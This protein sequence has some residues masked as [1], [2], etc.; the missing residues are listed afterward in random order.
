MTKKTLEET[1]PHLKYLWHPTLNTNPKYQFNTLTFGSEVKVHWQCPD[2]PHHW[3]AAVRNVVSLGTRCN[4]CANQVVFP[5][6]NDFETHNPDKAKYWDYE[7]NDKLPSEVPKSSAKKFWFICENGHSFDIKTNA[8]NSGNWCRYCVNR[9]V[10]PGENDVLTLHPSLREIWS[11]KNTIDPTTIP[12]GSGRKVVWECIRGHEWTRAVNEATSSPSCPQCSGR[13]AT[14]ERNVAVLYPELI[15]LY[16]EKNTT[17]LSSITP[18]SEIKRE[19]VCSE[20]HEWEATPSSLVRGT[21]C[22]YCSNRRISDTNSLSVTHPDISAEWHPTLNE[23]TPRDVTS[24]SSKKAYW[25]CPDNH[26]YYSL[27][28]NRTS[29][30]RKGCP[31]CSNYTS[32]AQRE[33]NQYIQDILPE[34]TEVITTRKALDGKEIDIYVPSLKVGF[35]YNGTYFHSSAVQTISRREAEKTRIAREKGIRLVHIW[36]HDWLGPK[37][38]IIKSLIRNVLNVSSPHKVYARKTEVHSITYKEASE[39]LE[40]HHIQGKASGSHY[41]SLRTKEDPSITVAV[42]VLTY[43]PKTKDMTLDRY[44]TSLHVPGGHSKLIKYVENNLTYKNIITFADLQYSYGDLYEKTGW[45]LDATIPPDYKYL[46][47]NKVHHKFNFRKKRFK[48][49]PELIHDPSLT[50]A[51]LAELNNIYRIWDCGKLRFIKPHVI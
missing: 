2:H 15:S 46:Y 40:K 1:H 39:F 37:Q 49:D 24:G 7:K 12:P 26:M 19:W 36:E 42:M 10:I 35:E 51:E 45:T 6:F 8:V 21:R 3:V 5:G 11:E 44:A 17:P 16:S 4:V 20:G 13:V 9:S 41:L 14:P 29:K 31:H 27:I 34:G 28:S 30:A 47:K 33:I 38:D 18:G 32:K 22:P 48:T 43:N 50:E 23:F 25:L